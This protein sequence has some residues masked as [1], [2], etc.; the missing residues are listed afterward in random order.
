MSRIAALLIALGLSW[1]AA[2][3]FSA[4]AAAQTLNDLARAM[5]DKPSGLFGS[6]EFTSN[7]LRALPQWRRVLKKFAAKRRTFQQCARTPSACTSK[8]LKSWQKVFPTV[9]GQ[10]RD[11]QLKAVNKYFNK[12]PYKTDREI[13]GV[14]EY[15]AAP[16]EFLARSGDCEDY[17]IAKFFALRQ[18]GFSNEELRVVIIWDRIRGIGHAVLSIHA[19]AQPLVLDSLTPMV[20][21]HSKYKH[22]VPQYSMNETTRWAHVHLGGKMPKRSL[23]TSVGPIL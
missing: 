11:T 7:S 5:K 20:L 15:W 6:I 17:A 2:T 10:S 13:Y 16:P 12:W 1:G 14:S 4:P 9:V 22:Y 3:A 8:V 18:L 23:G 19:T 21:K